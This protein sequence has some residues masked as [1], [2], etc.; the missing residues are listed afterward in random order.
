MKIKIPN[1]FKRVGVLMCI[2]LISG[3]C[4]TARYINKAENA[5]NDKRWDY[6]IRY[7]EK[8]NR[9]SLIKKKTKQLVKQSKANAAYYYYREAQYAV[10][11]QD[12]F[13]DKLHKAKESI[14]KSLYY[15]P[16]SVEYQSLKGD[17][18]AIIKNLKISISEGLQSA[19][20]L[21]REKK[22]IDAYYKCEAVLYSE[23]ENIKAKKL[24]DRIKK[25]GG[26]FYLKVALLYEQKSDYKSA[27]QQIEYA[28]ELRA[29]RKRLRVLDRIKRKKRALKLYTDCW[30]SISKGD[31]LS[32]LQ[33]AREMVTLDNHKK[34]YKILFIKALA[35]KIKAHTGKGEH[36]DIIEAVQEMKLAGVNNIK[37]QKEL[38]SILN[39]AVVTLVENAQKDS[40]MEFPGN[41]FTTLLWLDQRGLLP[42]ENR[43][44]LE[45]ARDNIYMYAVPELTV[46]AFAGDSEEKEDV[47]YGLSTSIMNKL[48]QDK[49]LVCNVKT[50]PES[51][52][53]NKS[54]IIWIIDEGDTPDLNT[55]GTL[56]GTSLELAGYIESYSFNHTINK[57]KMKKKYVS[58]YYSAENPAYLDYKREQEHNECRRPKRK[59]DSFGEAIVG[60][61]LEAAVG[62]VVDTAFDIVFAPPQ[63]I[64]KPVYSIYAYNVESH[65][66]SA[67][68]D[69]IIALLDKKTGKTVIKKRLTETVNFK[70]VYIP[71]HIKAKIKRDPLDI[72]DDLTIQDDLLEAAVCKASFQISKFIKAVPDIYRSK[73]KLSQNYKKAKEY[74]VMASVSQSDPD[75][76]V[77]HLWPLKPVT[78]VGF[79]DTGKGIIINSI[80]DDN[81]RLLNGDTVLRVNGIKIKDKYQLKRLLNNSPQDSLIRVLVRR[82]N[83]KIR[84][85]MVNPISTQHGCQNKYV[86]KKL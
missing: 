65:I 48:A 21:R 68:V 39:T 31:Y 1:Q 47:G 72:P 37:L 35:E 17:I 63:F 50:I 19:D 64:E 29:D 71:G 54:D 59:Y 53:V 86:G 25:K 45:T 10:Q 80:A 34:K 56:N 16:D 74:S 28:C 70:D 15:E 58:H 43:K 18:E 32:V 2:L 20:Q 49:T 6:A 27:L 84:M 75:T 41:T 13:L 81:H 69:F 52:P 44:N 9:K 83:K 40:E 60:S 79:S 76:I 24:S 14:D 57:K 11:Y 30:S 66:V 77:D 22:Y 33:Q 85:V 12:S 82:N 4:T 78:G 8:A 73:A 5:E 42:V 62:A 7:Y 67:E 46:S 55:V 51:L 26:A 23:P 3:G 61:L 36:K 38:N